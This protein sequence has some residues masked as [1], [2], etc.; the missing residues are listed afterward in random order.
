MS[1][2]YIYYYFFSE[3]VFENRVLGRIVGPSRDKIVGS[4][5]KQHNEELHNLYS[6]PNVTKMI[7]SKKRWTGHVAGTD[8]RKMHARFCCGTQKK[9]NQPLGKLRCT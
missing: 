1:D 6:S 3:S 4:L 2:K 7:K 9:R 8:R 5:R